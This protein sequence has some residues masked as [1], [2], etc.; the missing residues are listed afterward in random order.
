MSSCVTVLI[1]ACL[2]FLWRH[3]FQ[4]LE[5]KRSTKMPIKVLIGIRKIFPFIRV[6][7]SITQN[8]PKYVLGEI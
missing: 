6:H 4:A 8:L 7:P 3:C 1:V 5:P 2:K